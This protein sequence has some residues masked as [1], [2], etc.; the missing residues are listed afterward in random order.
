MQIHF[1]PFFHK[2]IGEVTMNS[3][4]TPQQWRERLER[5]AGNPE[6]LAAEFS[7]LEKEMRSERSS[8]HSNP[9]PDGLLRS[10]MSFLLDD[11]DDDYERLAKKIKSELARENR[12]LEQYRS[13]KPGEDYE[14][15]LFLYVKDFGG[16]LQPDEK[17][18]QF[19]GFVKYQGIH[20]TDTQTESYIFYLNEKFPGRDPANFHLVFIPETGEVIIKR[21]YRME[22]PRLKGDASPARAVLSEM[23]HEIVPD[24]ALITEF[25]VDNAANI[26]TRQALL[27]PG[28]EMGEFDAKADADVEK[29]PIGHL[30]KK[31]STELGLTPGEFKVHALPFGMLR[32]EMFVDR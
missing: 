14:D 7:E 13:W 21:V 3:G 28:K 5:A 18:V 17:G 29:T 32:I 11:K 9:S 20:T 19:P 16:K 31:L 30:M 6:T 22:L 26:K 24:L 8:L 10:V 2:A 12:L 25:E 15:R 27:E 4:V 23:V 1:A